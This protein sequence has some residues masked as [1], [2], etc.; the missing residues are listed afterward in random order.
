MNKAIATTLL[1]TALV[2]WDWPDSK[3]GEFPHIQAFQDS[4]FK[5]LESF[6]EKLWEVESY[7]CEKWEK[8]IIH[9]SQYST[10]WNMRVDNFNW[11]N[12]DVHDDWR[13]FLWH[14]QKNVADILDVIW[15]SGVS[16][17]FF[18]QWN[19]DLQSAEEILFGRNLKLDWSSDKEFINTFMEIKDILSLIRKSLSDLSDNSYNWL[20][21]VNPHD[22][23]IAHFYNIN[24]KYWLKNSWIDKYPEEPEFMRMM[25]T[26][27]DI[28]MLLKNFVYWDDEIAKITQDWTFWDFIAYLEN[29][30]LE[31]EVK[32][33]EIKKAIIE[34]YEYTYWWAEYW[35]FKKWY[36]RKFN[37][38]ETKDTVDY[39]DYRLKLHNKRLSSCLKD[40]EDSKDWCNG[41]YEQSILNL[42]NLRE[43][44]VL[45][46]IDAFYNNMWDWYWVPVL[47]FWWEYEFGEEVN[48]LNKRWGNQYCLINI[49]PLMYKAWKMIF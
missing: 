12:Q 22:I 18:N 38:S 15:A 40:Q 28:F 39:F 1:A 46:K 6:P 20:N 5:V 34:K 26:H 49:K 8:P 25:E 48:E 9:I 11:L 16:I 21:W 2:A 13:T 44:E 35:A 19:F 36:S 41:R 43:V 37:I 32:F 42:K 30:L 29:F 14:M 47:S 7:S 27:G 10:S 3:S 24:S 31:N 23:K 45:L 17:D 4:I 33:K